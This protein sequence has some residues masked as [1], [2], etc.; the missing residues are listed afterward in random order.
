MERG[1]EKKILTKDK[2][3]HSTEP[4]Q[5]ISKKVLPVSHTHTEPF[6]LRWTLTASDFK[7]NEAMYTEI[8]IYIP[9]HVTELF[10]SP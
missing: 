10:I 2:E 4:E 6:I 8:P 9:T 5:I 7:T 1:G 3:I